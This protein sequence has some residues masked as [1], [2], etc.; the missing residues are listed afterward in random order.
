MIYSEDTVSKVILVNPCGSAIKPAPLSHQWG[1][2][3]HQDSFVLVVRGAFK[4]DFTRKRE[5]PVSVAY[6][7][8]ANSYNQVDPYIRATKS[9]AVSP[10]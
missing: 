3:A 10:R 4:G 7:V 9:V 1:A 6:M 2:E 5:G 8:I